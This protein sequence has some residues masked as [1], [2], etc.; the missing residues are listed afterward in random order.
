MPAAPAAHAGARR[1]GPGP[2]LSLPFDG[3]GFT[4]RCSSYRLANGVLHNPANDR[5]TTAGVFHIA[6]GGLPIPDDKIAVPK[7]VFATAAR[8][9][10]P[11]AR[12]RPGAALHV[13][14]QTSPAACFVSLLLR[15]LVSPAVPGYA[16]E[17]RMEMRFIAPGG[18]VAN[19][20]FVEG[21]FGNAG[22]PYL[23][24]NDASLDPGDLDR[25]HRLRDPRAAPDPGD[26][27]GAR[28]AAR[29]ARR[30]NG[31]SATASAGRSRTSCTT[32]ARRSR[33]APATRAA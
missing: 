32:A 8:P 20:D 16:R 18:L 12:G 3:D 5:R 29:R 1:A 13:A 28:P 17:K 22:D 33:S 11:A 9:G 19:L 2:Q 30:P 27:E 21:I 15:P 10:L 7:A 31:S 14:D 23:P 24:E 6:E 26:E 25:A 4:R